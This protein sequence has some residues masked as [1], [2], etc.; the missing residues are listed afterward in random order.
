[1]FAE[2]LVIFDKRIEHTR[3]LIFVV[4]EEEACVS[5]PRPVSTLAPNVLVRS[6]SSDVD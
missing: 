3:Y 1:V 4:V 5:A 6:P 2:G